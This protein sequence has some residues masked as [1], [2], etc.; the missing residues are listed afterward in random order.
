MPFSDLNVRCH[1]CSDDCVSGPGGGAGSLP[2]VGGGRQLAGVRHCA[3]GEALEGGGARVNTERHSVTRQLVLDE[4]VQPLL[5]LGDA[6]QL[7][8]PRVVEHV[9]GGG[10][11]VPGVLPH[12]LGRGHAAGAHAAVVAKPALV[13]V[14]MC[15]CLAY[16]DPLLRVQGE[17]LTQQVDG[18][19]GGGGPESV[20][21][22]HCRRLT[23]PGE[24]VAL[25]GLAGVLHVGEAG[26]AQ[27]VSDQLQLLDGGRGLKHEDSISKLS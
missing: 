11:E 4:F 17:H 14:G 3:T 1:C 19:V 12:A 2:V 23:A 6:G 26:R 22:G 16:T 27:Q 25:G 9:L 24:H 13:K 20:Q 18:L 21:G 8:L 5:D 15:Q 7:E 10:L